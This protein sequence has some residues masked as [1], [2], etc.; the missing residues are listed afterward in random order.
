VHDILAFIERQNVDSTPFAWNKT[1]DEILASLE[2]FCR[3]TLSAHVPEI[4][5]RTSETGH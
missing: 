5:P 3:H 4:S 2:R 1:A